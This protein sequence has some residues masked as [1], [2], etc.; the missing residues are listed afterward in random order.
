MA[1]VLNKLLQVSRSSLLGN[2]HVVNP[3]KRIIRRGVTCKVSPSSLCKRSTCKLVVYTTSYA[4]VK[5]NTPRGILQAPNYHLRIAYMSDYDAVMHFMADTFFKSEPSMVNIG[6]AQQDRPD[7]L[8]F[9]Q[10]F[11]AVHNGLTIIALDRDTNCI[12]GAAVNVETTR[13]DV[14]EQERLADHYDRGP[15]RDLVRFFCFLSRQADPWSRHDTQTVF[16][17]ASVA[18]HP[19]HQGHGLAR[20]LVQESWVLAR[21]MAHRCFRIDASS[22]YTAKIADG[23]KWQ[24]IYSYPYRRFFEDGR[25]IFN[26]IKEPHT[27]IKIY[28]DRLDNCE[29]YYPPV[30]KCK[31]KAAETTTTTSTKCA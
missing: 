1:R 31:K 9:H 7:P 2:R 10:M 25:F 15:G 21:D 17:C 11:E 4:R 23:F 6:L 27:A 22:I 16:E 28:T 12:V 29:D 8:L 19:E 5:I 20:R 18:V 3:V 24:E 30:L 26:H 13:N 14:D